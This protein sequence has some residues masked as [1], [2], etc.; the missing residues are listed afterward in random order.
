VSATIEVAV[1]Q[2]IV[3]PVATPIGTPNAPPA[4]ALGPQYKVCAAA[5]LIG[6]A[7]EPKLTTLE[8]QSLDRDELEW[9]WS[10]LTNQLGTQYLHFNV[11]LRWVQE[12]TGT[13]IVQQIW[14]YSARV[15]IEQP[16]IVPGQLAALPVFG[17]IIGGSLTLPYLSER[18]KKRMNRQK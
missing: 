13:E 10:V 5:Y 2:T 16:W 12:T 9:E 15:E 7:F 17:S 6:K 14:H 4:Q 8:C 3:A 1:H 18:M 11:V